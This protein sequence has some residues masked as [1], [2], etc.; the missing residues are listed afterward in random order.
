V[1]T[2]GGQRF[3]SE[4]QTRVETTKLPE[5]DGHDTVAE[6]ALK[7]K[8]DQDWNRIGTGSIEAIEV[9]EAIEA[10]RRMPIVGLWFLH[11]VQGCDCA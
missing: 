2:H 4:C 5:V 10:P 3:P 6:V 11:R 1:E 9:I 7:L 8:W